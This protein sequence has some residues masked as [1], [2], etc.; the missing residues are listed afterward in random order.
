[1]K[2]QLVWDDKENKQVL[3]LTEKPATKEQVATME[4]GGLAASIEKFAKTEILDVPIVAVALG[5]FG[6][7]VVDKVIVQR[8]IAP[9]IAD[10]VLTQAQKDAKVA[11]YTMLIELGGAVA[12]AK[13]G[14]K[15]I[16]KSAANAMAFVLAYEG[17][18]GTLTRW[19]DSVW[20]KPA[21]AEQPRLNQARQGMNYGG[22]YQHPSVMQ[23]GAEQR[24]SGSMGLAPLNVGG[25]LGTYAGV[26]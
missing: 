15:L 25:Q 3:D 14:P 6:A 21:A 1:M 23:H 11:Q 13:F 26:F 20:P 12:I 22:Y 2:N 16:G 8:V 17:I 18:S 9:I 7:Y 24:G 5:A 4:A 10:T 19:L